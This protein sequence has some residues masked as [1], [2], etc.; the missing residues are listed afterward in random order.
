[1]AEDAAEREAKDLRQAYNEL[2]VRISADGRR[3]VA[4]KDGKELA[5][6]AMTPVQKKA[7]DKM[8]DVDTWNGK[9]KK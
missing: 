6:E 4:Y 1:M 9:A 3:P 2:N 5:Y 8:D 7:F